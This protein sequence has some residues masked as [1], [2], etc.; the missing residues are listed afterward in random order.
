[1]LLF[2]CTLAVAQANRWQQKVKYKMDI[3]MDVKS[4]Q[5]KGVQQL[6]YFNNSPYALKKVYYHLYY[7]AFQPGSSMDM[8]SQQHGK[9]L[10]G[11]KPDWDKRVQDRI[12][13]LDSSEIGYQKIISLKM[14]GI[15]QQYKYHETVLEVTLSKPIAPNSK[16]IFDLRFEAQ[17]PLQI[18]RTGRDNPTTGVRYSMSQWYPEMCEYDQEGWHA[19]P[20]EGREFYGVWGDYDV[21]V[22]IDPSYKLGGSGVLANAA[23]IG[24]GY[25]GV[26]ENLKPTASPTRKWHFVA[27]N[28]HDFMW[29]ADPDYVHYSRKIRTGL[30]VHAIVKDKATNMSGWKGLLD[31]FQNALP[32]IEKTF[33]EYAYP[34]FSFIEGGDGGMEYPMS[35]L[36][37][38]V[39]GA[40]HELM[41]SWFQGMIGT[42]ESAYPWMDEGFTEYAGVRVYADM[43]NK[44]ANQQEEAYKNYYAISRMGLEE[45]LT[46]HGDHYNTYLGYSCAVYYKGDIV[47]EQLGYI[48]G[49][50]IR[51][52]IL[53]SYYN[54]WKFKHPN[55]N[56]FMQVAET[57][58]GI[59]L[60]WYKE[61]WCATTK[62]I[63]YG[64]DSLWEDQSVSKIRLK[65][66][67]KMPMP[68]DL[69]VTYKDGSSELINIPLNLMLGN[70]SAENKAIPY[71]VEDEW[72]WT[73]STFTTTVRHK[74]TD[75]SKVEIDPSKRMADVD[76]RNNV[77][78]L[79]W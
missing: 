9:I 2:P 25:D 26:S 79:N 24:W 63:D 36:L 46:T 29:A 20:Y 50:E 15:P 44:K 72:R 7:N 45:P 58:S 43:A 11:N 16:V 51:D 37:A 17:V 18:R 32:T 5:F 66:I 69:Q 39:P 59:K 48:V 71:R 12:S 64:I 56:D 23:E 74:L 73:V 53:K 4:N 33:G 41:H 42:N 76:Q 1:M 13:L 75:I 47:L 62:T 31:M 70:K 67:G 61:F 57:V 60:D 8:A 35:T 40:M 54:T 34:Q 49:A 14:N 27:N 30:V 77:L 28:V 52:S 19:D 21:T 55:P 6:E 68:V 3:D 65:R 10:I 38:E 22:N 78:Q